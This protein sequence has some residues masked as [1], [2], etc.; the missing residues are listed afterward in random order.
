MENNTNLLEILKGPENMV[1]SN[2][3]AALMMNTKYQK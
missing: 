2:Y 1:L 3:E